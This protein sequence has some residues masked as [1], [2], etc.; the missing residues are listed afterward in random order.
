MA[1]NRPP[2]NIRGEPLPLDDLLDFATID[3]ADIE[4]AAEWWD[5]HASPDWIGALDAEPVDDDA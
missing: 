1:P 5:E 3:A 2:N 4:N